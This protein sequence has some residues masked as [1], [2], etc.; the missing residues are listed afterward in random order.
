M[1][2]DDGVIS[3]IGRKNAFN[4]RCIKFAAIR[5]K[6]EER[7]RR[8]TM[9]EFTLRGADA[10]LIVFDAINDALQ[11]VMNYIFVARMVAN[12]HSRSVFP[13]LP[14]SIYCIPSGD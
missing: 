8:V 14:F 4:S 6:E 3:R 5:K 13:P 2:I 10:L 1:Q 12:A 11:R 9:K 7:K